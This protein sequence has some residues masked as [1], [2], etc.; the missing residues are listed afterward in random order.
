M[1]ISITLDAPTLYR[2]LP[3]TL[4]IPTMMKRSPFEFGERGRLYVRDG[5]VLL[6]QDGSVLREHS[7][8]FEFMGTVELTALPFDVMDLPTFTL[9][10]LD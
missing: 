8:K 10:E 3:I 7:K 4:P 9:E 6:I 2:D 5:L 1:S